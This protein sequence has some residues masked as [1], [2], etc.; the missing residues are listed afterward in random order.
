MKNLN[1]TR[2]NILTK[3]QIIDNIK[4]VKNA[5]VNAYLTEHLAMLSQYRPVMSNLNSKKVNEL[6]ELPV[7]ET[8]IYSEIF[9]RLYSIFFSSLF[10]NNYSDTLPEKIDK[11]IVACYDDPD[12]ATTTVKFFEDPDIY[13][14]PMFM[15]MGAAI[16]AA[17]YTYE[18]ETDD[19]MIALLAN[20]TLNYIMCENTFNHKIMI[21]TANLTSNLLSTGYF[22]L[23]DCKALNTTNMLP[24]EIYSFFGELNENIEDYKKQINNMSPETDNL[25]NQSTDM[26]LI[27]FNLLKMSVNEN[28]AQQKNSTISWSK[29]LKATNGEHDNVFLAFMY[30]FMLCCS[31]HGVAF[32]KKSII[33]DTGTKYQF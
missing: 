5:F 7:C 3:D 33:E 4:I 1:H 29:F 2:Q 17:V 19:F 12:I 24:T 23:E 14:G 11:F 26:V 6:E 30:T 31:E 22:K 20:D 13:D 10:S 16:G 9:Y 18:G 27:L 8:K 15:L 28:E 32:F 25:D 21:A